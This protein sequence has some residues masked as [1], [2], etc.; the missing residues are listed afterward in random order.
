MVVLKMQG[1]DRRQSDKA[2]HPVQIIGNYLPHNSHCVG[3]KFIHLGG[4]IPIL[5]AY[6][7]NISSDQT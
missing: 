5:E 3:N 7:D 4:S 2:L 1:L 6:N